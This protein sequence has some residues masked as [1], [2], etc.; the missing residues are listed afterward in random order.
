MARFKVTS[1]MIKDILVRNYNIK[2]SEIK[3]VKSPIGIYDMWVSGINSGSL[4]DE[5]D[6]LLELETLITK[7][8]DDNLIRFKN[9]KEAFT[10][11]KI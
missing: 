9:I 7:E 1:N 8:I 2:K 6:N 11:A 10:N 5:P 4:S 3:C